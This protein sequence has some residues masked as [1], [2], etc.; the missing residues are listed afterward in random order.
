MWPGDAYGVMAAE[1]KA[2]KTWLSLDLLVSCATGTKFLG[3]LATGTP[4][5]V[6]M[7]CGEGAERSLQRRLR[8]VCRE[9]GV[10]MPAALH[11]SCF[12]PNLTSVDHLDQIAADIERVKPRLV[13]LDPLYLSMG[14]KNMASL[15]EVGPVLQAIQVLCESAGAALVIVHHFNQTGHGQSAR[16]MSGAGPEEWGRVLISVSVKSEKEGPTT[17]STVVD[18]S[19]AVKGSEV[20]AL[21]F[22]VQRTVWTDDPNSLTAPM[23]Y[24][25][26]CDGPNSGLV[27]EHVGID[28]HVLSLLQEPDRKGLAAQEILAE[29]TAR[30]IDAQLRTVQAACKGLVDSGELDR[31]GEGGRGG[32]RYSAAQQK[33]K[34]A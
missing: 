6:L 17:G 28:A 16:R 31:E 7:Y 4:G 12:A 29:L 2:G 34:A 5:D 33:T 8:A 10:T 21:S 26:A 25:V 19:V 9:R 24:T 32:Y 22:D 23:H 27:R 18:L 11:Y 15:T 20:P 30:E 14:G 13:V 1:P 3:R